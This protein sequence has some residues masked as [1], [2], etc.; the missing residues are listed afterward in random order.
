MDLTNLKI[1][2]VFTNAQLMEKFGVSNSGGMRRSRKNNVLILVHKKDSVYQDRWQDDKLLYTGMGLKGDQDVNFGQNKT[3]AQSKTNGVAVLL[4][5]NPMPNVYEY[6]GE[7]VLAG[8][9]F[10]EKQRDESNKERQ[11]V[12]FPLC[13]KS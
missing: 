2:T 5:N 9:P 1:S 3:L 12:I 8:K 10:Y 6:E 11:V 4:F 13:F 7:V